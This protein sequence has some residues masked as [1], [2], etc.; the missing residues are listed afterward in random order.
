MTLTPEQW[1]QAKTIVADAVEQDA[2]QQISYATARCGS[3]AAL[4][5]EVLSLLKATNVTD[6]FLVTPLANSTPPTAHTTTKIGT[7]MGAWQLI[8]QIGQGGMGVVYLAKR[9]DGAYEQTAALKT[10]RDVSADA[11]QQRAMERERQTLAQLNHPNIARLLDGGTAQDG[12]PFLV[13]EYVAGQTI[14]QYCRDKR[15]DLRGRIALIVALCEAVQSAHQALVIHRDIKPSNVMVSNTGEPKLL[16]FGVA[17]LLETGQDA[18]AT[19]GPSNFT[20]RYASPEQMQGRPVTVATDVYAIGLL[21]YDVLAGDSPYPGASR[22]SQSNVASVMRAVLEE[23][24]M[25]ASQVATKNLTESTQAFSN[26]LKGELDIILQK[27]CAKLATDRFATVAALKEDLQRY[28]QGRPILARPQGFF[29]VA[30]KF[31]QRNPIVCALGTA[32]T[33]AVAISV[34]IA[35][36]QGK[37]AE[38]RFNDVRK[39]SRSIMFDYHDTLARIP[40]ALPAQQKLVAD[41]VQY[42]DSLE[43]TK[44]KDPILLAELADGYER[45]GKIHNG[46]WVANLGNPADAEAHFAKAMQIR[47][48]LHDDNPA[49]LKYRAQLAE[50]L[51]ERA[52]QAGRT[53]DGTTAITSALAGI[54]LLETPLEKA[55][56][57]TDPKAA[58]VLGKLMLFRATQDG[59]VNFS[60]QG[61]SAQAYA[62]MLA[63]RPTQDAIYKLTASLPEFATQAAIDRADYLVESGMLSVCTGDFN[64]AAQ[65]VADGITVLEQLQLKQ[66]EKSYL[67]DIAGAKTELAGIEWHRANYA[68]AADIGLAALAQLKQAEAANPSDEQAAFVVTLTQAKVINFL[69][70]TGRYAES[71]TLAQN[72]LARVKEKLKT[73]PE[74]QFY[75]LA[76]AT[77]SSALN[78]VEAQL[79]T[80]ATREAAITR[81]RVLIA[82]QEAALLAGYINSGPAIGSIEQVLAE[83]ITQTEPAKACTLHLSALKR[84]DTAATRDSES[85]AAKLQLLRSVR[86]LV[87]AQTPTCFDATQLQEKERLFARAKVHLKALQDQNVKTL[88]LDE[89][90]ATL[91]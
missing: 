11:L 61:K 46:I 85:V 49:S 4:L 13:M 21:L 48:K 38:Q 71:L 83:M 22:Y 40:G 32:A 29:Y 18:H 6:R 51:L 19:Q 3:D 91:R 54:A 9:A 2:A 43:K 63:K 57:A 28:L 50:S 8:E 65:M 7:Q 89:L 88:D 53:K 47:Q 35:L 58:L 25:L 72:T 44:P 60:S 16:D 23:T 87:K 30:K 64:L 69:Y 73:Q 10:L 77:V 80:G 42:L 62:F 12:T 26:G 24:P 1:Q 79:A 5:E 78:R 67:G 55:G 68:A 52:K 17:R 20:P 70:L 59:C 74:H 39:I 27:A 37:L 31:I 84:M 34:G 33:A 45:L 14:D 81:Q 75:K 86:R 76:L 82:Q 15:L 56:L 36:Q 41:A 66:L 90:A